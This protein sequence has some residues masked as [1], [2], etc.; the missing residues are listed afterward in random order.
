MQPRGQEF[1]LQQHSECMSMRQCVLSNMD[2]GHSTPIRDRTRSDRT[3]NRESDEAIGT[4]SVTSYRVFR[5][6]VL[7]TV[8]FARGLALVF[9]VVVF[10][11]VRDLGVGTQNSDV[12][13]FV[14]HS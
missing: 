13:S 1:S 6:P 8:F 4:Y 3:S 10:L 7:D 5:V 2:V 14:D 12:N 9:F 11:G